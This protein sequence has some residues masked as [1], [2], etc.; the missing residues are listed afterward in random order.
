MAITDAIVHYRRFL[1]RRNYSAHTIRNYMYTL[2]QF[3]LW[4]DVPIE[5]VTHKILL[6]YIDHLLDRRLRPKTINCHLD[7]IRGFYNYLIHEEQVAMIHP[8]KRGYTLRLSR[9]LPRYIKEENLIRL[10]DVI[11][12]RRDRAMFMLMLR[13]G[14]RVEEVAKLTLAAL[15]L[16]RLQL[17]VYEGKGRKD[18]IVYLSRDALQAVVDYLRVRLSSR[19]RRLFLVE[20]GT[21]KGKGI[22]VRGIQKRME[23]YAK[24]IGLKVSCHQLRHTMATQLLNADADLVTIQDL[25]GHSRIKT[26]QRYCKVSNLKVQRD[27]HKAI[28]AVM[29]RHGLAEKGLTGP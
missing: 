20:K 10:F 6:T 9:P 24:K 4:V 19:T 3:I 29:Q 16:R 12:S 11:Q 2:R 27:Y 21:C 17:I 25:L 5:Q 8:I 23:Y 15:D 13:C 22:S 18:R 7:S 28:G 26:T 1:K 14:L